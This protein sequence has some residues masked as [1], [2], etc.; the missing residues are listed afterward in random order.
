MIKSE[1]LHSFRL[2]AESGS[3]TRAAEQKSLSAMA[4]SKQMSKLETQ[5]GQSLFERS[6]RT[7][8][9]TEFGQQFKIEAEKVLQAQDSL[10]NWMADKTGT[11]S[12]TLR[13]LGQSPLVI[14]ETITPWLK[15]FLD[16]YPQ[17]NVELDV[18]ESLINIKHDEYDIFW[19]I[20]DYLG[21]QFP[22]L[23]RRQLWQSSYGVYASP[24]YLKKH[25]TPSSPDELEDHQ[26][27]GYLYNSPA[28]VLVL[29]QDG[30]PLYKFL[31]QRVATVTGSIEMAIQGL[32]LLN[33]GDDILQIREAVKDRQLVPVLP[34]YWWQQ[35][36]IH[37][38]FHNVRHPQPKV[39]AFIE[40]FL[41]KKTQWL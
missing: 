41:D 19:G 7:L 28:N 30:E 35:A 15:E 2:V 26:V 9:L 8:R 25:G 11:V 3:I 29:E 17:L 21:E 22:D 32:G 34:D 24:D 27:I 23:K 37:L 12:G 31:K 20:S 18:R 39:K 5:L 13:V 16:R 1:L 38:Y 40:F 6:G 33:A 36:Q 4:L 14:N 10:Q